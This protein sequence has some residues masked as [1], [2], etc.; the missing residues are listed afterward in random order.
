MG[1]AV[2]GIET[3]KNL[4]K[5]FPRAVALLESGALT[6]FLMEEFR[7]K[8][9]SCES[10]PSY[11]LYTGSTA[12]SRYK[13]ETEGGY[14]KDGDVYYTAK[15]HVLIPYVGTWT[16]RSGQSCYQI[17]KGVG[18]EINATSLKLLEE[19]IKEPSQIPVLIQSGVFDK[20]RKG[21]NSKYNWK[22]PGAKMVYGI[23][24]HIMSEGMP[25]VD[26]TT[27][28]DPVWEQMALTI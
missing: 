17:S 7:A 28:K 14:G 12:S 25:E 11:S 4:L 19:G 22:N 26:V 15:L 20:M 16:Q 2:P 6:G 9:Q 13:T 10:D 18:Y 21:T 5:K 8:K 27:E 23:L 3:R 1:V 24:L